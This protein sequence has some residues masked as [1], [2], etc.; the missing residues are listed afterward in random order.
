MVFVW[1]SA[2][3]VLAHLDRKGHFPPLH[4]KSLSTLL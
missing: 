3:K 4:R 2:S 1:G